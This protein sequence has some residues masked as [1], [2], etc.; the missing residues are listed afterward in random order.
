[1]SSS[2]LLLVKGSK[3]PSKQ[4]ASKPSAPAV[5]ADQQHQGLHCVIVLSLTEFVSSLVGDES[6]SEEQAT[7]TTATVPTGKKPGLSVLSCLRCLR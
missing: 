6:E 7:T 4:A 5:Q 2:H 3:A 1:M